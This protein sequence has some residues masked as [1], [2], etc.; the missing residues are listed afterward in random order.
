MNIAEL[1]SKI[2]VKELPNFLVFTG[3]ETGIMDVYLKQI[4]TVF[5][6]SVCKSESVKD[7]IKLCRGTSIFKKN[8]LFIVTD[9]TDFLKNEKAWG[10][11]KLILGT[12]SIILKYH[13]YDARLGFWKKFS[14]E[15]VVFERLPSSIVAKHISKEFGLSV[16]NAIKLAE[17]YDNDYYRC[18]LEADKIKHLSQFKQ[19]TMDTAFEHCLNT[20][21]LCADYNADIFN[22]VESILRKD[23]R[24]FIQLY[25]ALINQNEPILRII[26]ALYM[27]IKN[28][29]IAQTMNSAKNI[30]QNAGI[31]YYSYV[32]AK[33]MVGYYSNTELENILYILMEIEQGI[34]TGKINQEF[35][36]DF[37]LVNL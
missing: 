27:G 11:I 19:L 3:P 37:L 13:N 12:N 17:L 21:V 5:K 30:Q 4:A 34:K 33:E 28:V 35:S 6:G 23:Y 32:K 25:D 36:I 9:D 1:K 10:N 24:L 20:G 29:L 7:V 2:I 31:S 22:L 14:N 16:E 15:T 18:K 8:K 26:S